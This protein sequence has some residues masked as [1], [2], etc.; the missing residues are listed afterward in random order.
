M[1]ITY[2]SKFL[3]M[4][5]QN[6]KAKF[7]VLVVLS[8]FCGLFEFLGVAM[9]FPLITFILNPLQVSNI[10]FLP[11][12]LAENTNLLL[13]LGLLIVF[14]FVIKNLLMIYKTYYQFDFLKIWQNELN[15]AVFRKYIYSS[16]ETNLKVSQEN[17]VFQVWNLSNI[18][19]SN[20]VTMVL[21]LFSNLIIITI[22]FAF[23]L[24]KFNIWAIVTCSFFLICGL[25]QNKFFKSI[26]RTLT[27]EKIKLLATTNNSFLSAIKSFKDIKIYAKE[28]HFYD[29]Y[30]KQ[31]HDVGRVDSLINFFN[32]IPQNIVEISI[33]FSIIIMCYGIVKTSLGNSQEIIASFSLLAA[34]MFRMAPIINKL[35]ANLNIINMSKPAVD[36]FFKAY[37]FYDEIKLNEAIKNSLHLDKKIIVRNL[38]YSYGYKKILDNLNL[39][40]NKGEFIG[41]IGE[42]GVGKSTFLNVLMGILTSYEGT[43]CV[44][45]ERLSENSIH[46]W[47]SLI[48][49]VPQEITIL[50]ASIASNIAFCLN[51]SEIDYEKISQIIKLVQLTDYVQALPNGENE[52]LTDLSGLSVGQKQRIGLARALYKQPQ[53]LFLDEVTAALDLET[54]N[55]IV[56]CL[57][58]LKGDKTIIA[59]AHRLS[60]LKNCDKIFYFKSADTV[61]CGTFEELFNN[62]DEFKSLINLA[63]LGNITKIKDN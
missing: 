45:N 28:D 53:I 17:S 50:P 2:F 38:S 31:V 54:E 46:K 4:F 8:V 40:I 9:I 60:T 32:A 47:M 35:Q 22:V 42:S 58:E 37:A 43:I 52:I 16:F 10:K 30:K 5:S 29:V 13:I 14:A 33:I 48:G 7:I 56:Q 36:S 55:K 12:N 21:N 57:N 44:D 23:L 62:D 19:F 27:H 61:M 26:G 6:Y 41:I 3:R 20:F 63:T 49:Y 15:L 34:A 51:E 24:W 59:I 25:L 11:V 39:E 1:F 18:V